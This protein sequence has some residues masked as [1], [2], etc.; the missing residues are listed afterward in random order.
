GLGTVPDVPARHFCRL[1]GNLEPASRF[2]EQLRAEVLKTYQQTF[3]GL[4][5]KRTRAAAQPLDRLRFLEVLLQCDVRAA[6]GPGEAI[7]GL[8]DR[9]LSH[10]GLRRGANKFSRAPA[11]RSGGGLTRRTRPRPPRRSAPGRACPTRAPGGRRPTR[12]RCP[13]TTAARRRSCP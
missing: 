3:D 5:E 6:I 2:V 4:V 11:K 1:D 7:S 12:R 9:K 10:P 8:L 13:S